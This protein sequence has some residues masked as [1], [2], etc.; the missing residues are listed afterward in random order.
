M[1]QRS[2]S[3]GSAPISDDH[4]PSDFVRVCVG[5]IEGFRVGVG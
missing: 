5:P 1:F 3:G 4:G 2:L